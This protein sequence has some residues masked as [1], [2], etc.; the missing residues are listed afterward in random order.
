MPGNTTLD[1]IS[2]P[3]GPVSMNNRQIKSVL[4][5]TA[6]TDAATKA[7]VDAGAPIGSMVQWPSA[8]P[9]TGWLLCNGQTVSNATYPTLFSLLGLTYGSIGTTPNIGP[10]FVDNPALTSAQVVASSTAGWSLTL[11]YGEI[12]SG[13]AHIYLIMTRTGATIS[14]GNPNHAQQNVGA[15]T[16][17]FAP[18][19]EVG[20]IMA[21]APRWGD[22]RTSGTVNLMSG[23]Q[24]NSFTAANITSGDAYGGQA[25]YPMDPTGTLPKVYT[26]IKAL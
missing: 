13:M 5:P 18:M 14:L 10:A 17:N 4:G 23:L 16:G 22:L 1:V 9:P 7:Y 25:T 6:N 11:N 8:T 3:A 20:I 15:L 26:I 12:R 19:G 21:N 24:S 2:A